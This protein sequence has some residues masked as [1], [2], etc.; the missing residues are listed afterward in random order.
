VHG[1]DPGFRDVAA[2]ITNLSGRVSVASRLIA[3]RPAAPA[4]AP[5]KVA[6]QGTSGPTAGSRPGGGREPEPPPEP[7]RKNRKIGFV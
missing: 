1:E 4:A 3:K 6:A 2:R 7:A 5:R